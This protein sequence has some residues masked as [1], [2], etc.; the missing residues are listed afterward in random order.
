MKK[1]LTEEQFRIAIQKLQPSRQTVDIAHGILVEG[2]RHGEYVKLYG[3]TKSA[4]SQTA[5]RVW[6]AVDPMPAG[7]ERVTAILPAHQA[8]VVRKWALKAEAKLKRENHHEN[9]GNGDPEGRTGQDVRDLSSG[10]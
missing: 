1:R 7:F 3:I 2:R 5:L 4:V 6:N 10:V 9:A 8:F